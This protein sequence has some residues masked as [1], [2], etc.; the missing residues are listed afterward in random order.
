[1]MVRG[2]VQTAIWLIVL[3]AI[4]FG[5]GGDWAWPRG[6][7]FIVEMAVSS[8]LIGGWLARHDPALF[9]SRLSRPFQRDQMP[10]D[11]LFLAGAMIAFVA[12]LVLMGLDGRRFGWSHAPMPIPGQWIPGQWF[13]TSGAVLIALCMILVWRV[14]RYNS[15]A[16]PQV[17]IQADRGQRV[18]SD[19][20]Y[21]IVRHP[22]YA[23][24]ILYFLGTPLL[25]GSW[26]GLLPVPLFVA[27]L[28]AR[29]VG[30][31]RMLRHALPAYND[32]A[33]RVRFRLVPGVW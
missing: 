2:M 17:R 7:V 6:W 21:R 9:E 12:W 3:G 22:M 4:L 16:A 10:W 14:F 19:G 32:Y 23:A 8:V 31:E 11:R 30:E 20:P 15:F 33:R 24:A 29:A 1:M 13:E 5:S 27:G 26:W 25:L 28:G 18:I